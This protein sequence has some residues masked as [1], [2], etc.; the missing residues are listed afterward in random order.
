MNQ[1]SPTA[2]ERNWFHNNRRGV[3][4]FGASRGGKITNNLFS[5]NTMGVMLI[6]GEAYCRGADGTDSSFAIGSPRNTEVSHNLV[7]TAAL[8]VVLAEGGSTEIEG[9]RATLETWTD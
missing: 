5:E 9:N 3:Q 7:V 6:G 4:I 1:P 2:V 8:G